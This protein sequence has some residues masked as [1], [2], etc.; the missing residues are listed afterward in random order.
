VTRARRLLTG[1]A[2]PGPAL[3]LAVIALIGAFLA[4]GGPRE[5]TSLQNSALR[6]TLASAGAFGISAQADWQL[7]GGTPMSAGQIQLAGGV[8]GGFIRPPLIAPAGQRW[9]GLTLPFLQVQGAAPQAILGGPPVLEVGYRSALTR[10]A[11]LISGSL[12]RAA[13]TSGH[14]TV[15][16]AAVT[17]ATAARFGLRPGSAI[18][19]G[20]L[21]SMPA[22]APSL[23]LRVTG[24]LAPTG[25]S[26]SFWT[27]DPALAGPVVM[28]MSAPGGHA[29]GGPNVW[30]AGVLV[31][32]AELAAVQAAYNGSF[33][34]LTWDYPVA[35]GG[36]TAAQA[37]GMLAVMTSLTSGDA[38]AAALAQAAP[39]LE[40]PPALT[41]GGAGTLAGFLAAQAAVGSTDA[42]LLAGVAAAIAILLLVG[43]VVLAGAYRAELTLMRARGAST[44]QVAARMLG[45]SAGA[46]GPAVAAGVAA[47]VAAVP[48]GGN[49]VSWVL[50]ALVAVIA[51]AAPALLAAWEHRGLRSLAGGRRGDLVIGRRSARRVVAEATVVAIIAGAVVAL[52]VRGLTPGAG[53][54]P[55]LVAAPVLIAV[56][57]GLIAAR[58]YPFPLR[59]LLR[60]TSARRGPV[61]YLGIARSARSRPVP[62]LPAL[63][64][65]VAIAVIALGGMVRAAVTGGQEAASWRQ[66]GADALV[67]AAGRQISIGPPAQAAIAAAPG[68]ARAA[69]VYVAAPGAPGQGDLLIGSGGGV[70]AG[71]VIADPA[72][73]A[74]L[75]AGTPW[76]AF[77][78]RALAPPAHGGA[79]AGTVPV[80][81]SPGVAA[82][83]GTGPRR[84]AFAS[85]Q[86]TIRVAATVGSTPA[87]PGG[88]SFLILPSWASPRLAA[89][90]VPD[91]MLLTGSAIDVP[92]L[93]AVVARVLPGGQVVSR[94]AVL[95]AAAGSPAVRGSDLALDLSAAAAAA[96]GAAAVL[97]G[98]L[99]A[100]RDRTRLGVWLTAMGMTSRQA[101]RL[102][103]LDAL[104]LLL[105]AILGG[106]LAGLAAGPLIGPGLDLSAFTGSSAPVPVRPDLVALIAPA[107]GAVI[108]IMAA[109]MGQ[110]ALI[111]SRAAAVLRV[112]DGGSG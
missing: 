2:G 86:L 55:Y 51:L 112:D 103:L 47:A 83:M 26:S 50:A 67:G 36:L 28:Q 6:Q 97:L 68:V 95:A 12:P 43:A 25:P 46:A 80:I 24:L 73:Y 93:R 7:T 37:P 63:A 65:V 94:A 16:Q 17:A 64:L 3:A 53:V 41:A 88:G 96:C 99:L 27:R 110:N 79:A 84:L 58:V 29:V 44:G 61:G 1:E 57:A 32:P 22:G 33:A 45:T 111:R 35:T 76:P 85:S 62:L 31:G 75:V 59:G 102:A 108:L 71:V 66:V 77:P 15:V 81:A 39:P 104:P 89:S 10:H 5:V 87:L 4:T 18:L 13:T 42:L 82:A 91:A 30:A 23:V 8:M 74:A 107:A 38:G 14:A 100:G 72:R 90:T 56:A 34:T 11:R 20:R 48:D 106:E 69:A 70:Q 78:A 52:R 54:D 49:T 92:A 109:A 98:V 105:I 21:P 19:L 9:A 60:F 40:T 101:R